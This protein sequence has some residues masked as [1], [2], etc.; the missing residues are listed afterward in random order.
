MYNVLLQLLFGED[1]FLYI[2]TG[3]GGGAGDP[4]GFSQSK[5]SLLGKALRIDVSNRRR[6]TIPVDN[7]FLGEAAKPEI[8]AYGLRNPWRCSVDKG[9]ILTGLLTYIDITHILGLYNMIF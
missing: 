6:Y 2:F 7:P 1:K 4:N 8:Y 5:Q 3:D 9:D